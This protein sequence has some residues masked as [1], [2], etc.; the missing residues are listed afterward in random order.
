M[1][2]VVHVLASRDEGNFH[3]FYYL[4]DGLSQSSRL[5]RYGLKLGRKYVYLGKHPYDNEVTNA[6]KF[7]KVE[8]A[9]QVGPRS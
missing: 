4:Y 1:P 7:T 9:L 2:P 3:I 6:Q 8:E 5:A